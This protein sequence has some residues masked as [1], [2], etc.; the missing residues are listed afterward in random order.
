[1]THTPIRN[2]EYLANLTAKCVRYVKRCRYSNKLAFLGGVVT[3]A[4]ANTPKPQLRVS[5]EFD[6]EL[7]EANE[8]CAQII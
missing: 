6:C 4:M 3:I 8:K 5:E 7:F 1:M 2:S